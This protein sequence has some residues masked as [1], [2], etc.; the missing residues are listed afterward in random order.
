VITEER[1]PARPS[2]VGV[3]QAIRR[4]P[5]LVIVPMLVLGAVGAA[6]GY[7]RKPTYE[8]S[9][10]LAVGQLN[11]AD[12]AAVGVVVQAT[13]TLAGVYA[14]LIDAGGLQ[15]RVL[16]N[17]GRNAAGS[18]IAATPIPGSPLVRVTATADSAGVAVDVANG[19]SRALKDYAAQYADTRGRSR[20]ISRRVRASVLAVGR[21][22][23]RV[24][25][26]RQAFG[27]SPSTANRRRLNEAE[28]DLEGAKLLRDALR[29]NYQV[30]QQNARLT[31][32]LRTFR[33]AE[34]ATSDR[35][36]TMELLGL[37][38]LVAGVAL[39]AALATARLNRRV[40]RLTSP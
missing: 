40:A 29:I 15:E 5:L 16:R 17:V 9:A 35:R 2:R 31:P 24:D 7:A 34:G 32:P 10:E 28:A 20:T 3:L 8:A 22:Q 38:G 18:T 39:G 13:Q 30:A 14:R 4:Y 37:I 25:Q 27:S 36:H 21:Q 26:A 6:L 1:I 19:A 12:P 11:V 23:D 33:V